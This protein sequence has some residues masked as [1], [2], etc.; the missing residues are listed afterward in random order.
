M[1]YRYC[2]TRLALLATSEST[3]ETEIIF[4][5][6]KCKDFQLKM[7]TSQKVDVKGTKCT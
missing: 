3:Y 4:T 7:N 1:F 2:V 5:I 6:S